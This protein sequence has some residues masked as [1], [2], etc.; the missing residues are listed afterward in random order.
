MCV[1]LLI[2]FYS[3]DM[4]QNG[5]IVNLL[6]YLAVEDSVKKTYILDS[7]NDWS[8]L[9]W[10][11]HRTSVPKD[12][13]GCG[14]S[15]ELCEDGQT[16]INYMTLVI[17]GGV[18]LLFCVIF[19]LF[20]VWKYQQNI[21][22]KVLESAKIKWSDV[23]P[24]DAQPISYK[25]R[26]NEEVV[27]LRG[28]MVLREIVRDVVIDVSSNIIVREL[29][30][31]LEL[32]NND[33]LVQ[34]VGVCLEPEHVSI[35]MAWQSRGSLWNMIEDD[36]TEFDLDVKTSIL[37]DIACGMAYLHQSSV[38]AHGWLT[39]QCCLIDSRWTCKISGYGLNTF[40][41]QV[42]ARELLYTT[43]FNLLWMAPEVLAEHLIK[44]EGDV[45][46]YGIIVQEVMLEDKPFAFNDVTTAEEIIEL[47]IG[48]SKPSFRPTLPAGFP[49]KWQDLMKSC[50]TDDPTC[51]PLFGQ[52][53]YKLMHIDKSIE[54]TL[55]QKIVNRLERHTKRLEELVYKRKTEIENEKHKM[56]YLLEELLPNSVI[57]QLRVRDK[58]QPE[59]FEDSTL[60]FSDLVGFTQISAQSSP[61]EIV[62]MLNNMY[63][64]FDNVA[65][66]FDVYKIATIGDAYVVASGIPIR[67]GVQ[68]AGE[69]CGMAEALLEAIKGLTI[70][71]LPNACLQMRIGVH[72]GPCV[73]GV[74]G[75]KMPRYLL[76]GDTVDI[77]SRMESVGEP[78]KIHITEATRDL[79]CHTDRFKIVL[80]AEI[81]I[82]GKARM[83]TFWLL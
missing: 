49:E 46:S 13:P 15:N 73:A 14:W 11:G 53:L 59:I 80:R 70:D 43:P 35:F 26:H 60:F 42:G 65:S 4:I 83:K 19:V 5:K 29:T 27:E 30:Q 63:T 54:L 78:M 28:E 21:I 20:T 32:I 48:R 22:M 12:K 45:Y 50:W 47:V 41:Q 66:R 36:E 6:Q 37:T 57:E 38:G 51:R 33:N 72:S 18:L 67:N 79:I 81:E 68:H 9:I 31:V 56:E 75:I 55:V 40:R 24:L 64:C 3:L 61:L 25:C 39:S 69:I 23:S 2:L 82:K 16:A 44:K 58:V 71:H 52:I 34:F 62:E 8:G 10:Y 1:L 76:F 74:V 17:V 7:P 77:A